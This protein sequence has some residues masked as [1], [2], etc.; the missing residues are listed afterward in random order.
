MTTGDPYSAS[1]IVRGA[2]YLVT[3]KAITSL[4]GIGTF[5]LLIRT[6]PVEE[7]AVYTILFAL[8][9]LVDA[10][11]GFGLSHVLARYVPELFGGRR[12]RTLR[13][14]V[15]R[16]IALRL[17]LLMLFL[18]AIYALAAQT[19]PLIGLSNWEWAFQAYLPVV[20]VRTMSNS[21]FSLL[22]SMLHQGTAQLGFTLTTLLRFILFALAATHGSLDL[23]TVIAIELATDLVGAGIL[24][25]GAIRVMPKPDS[26]TVPDETGWIRSNL[27]RMSDFGIK[28]YLQHMLVLPYGG[29]TN[30]LLV[31]GALSSGQVALFGFAQS[32]SDLMERYLPMR[33]LAG[34]TRPVL[35]A[36]YVRDRRFQDLQFAANLLFKINAIV[37]CAA[38]V[39]IFGGGRQMIAVV[40]AGKY[41]EGGVSLLMIMCAL[42]MMYSLR[43]M[44]D[45][46]C[47][48]VE[49]NGPLIWS[50]TFIAL[51]VLPGI[52]LLP[53]LGVYALPVANLIG[54]VLGCAILVRRLHAEGFAYRHDMVGLGRML[55]ATGVGLSA[56]EL[57]RWIGGE[58]TI[59]LAGGIVFFLAAIPV[60]RPWKSEEWEL[61]AEMIRQLRHKDKVSGH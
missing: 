48:A 54:L 3:G 15:V 26:T 52:A 58:W 34:V 20:L 23:Q 9:E 38:A 35:T 44:L 13:R 56:S 22:E 1:R 53:Y 47:H 21:L 61:V 5:L 8:V 39:A 32:V 17:A 25:T 42:V 7:F 16:L 2:T 28:G 45:Q 33:M 49:R 37:V 55:A 18:I 24:L 31:G 46:V 29:A 30:R 36:R 51:S 50:N 57:I 6:L 14:F 12:H 19:A 4:A 27:A 11:T 40:S 41:D 60:M 43:T 59:S 10:I